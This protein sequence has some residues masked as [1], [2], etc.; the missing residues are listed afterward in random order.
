MEP[1]PRFLH[2]VVLRSIALFGQRSAIECPRESAPPRVVTFAELD[3]GGSRIA[4]LVSPH[5][6]GECIVAILLPRTSPDWLAAQ[7]GVLRAGAAFVC[8]EHSYPDER[9]SYLLTDSDAVAV[10]CEREDADRVRTLTKSAVVLDVHAQGSDQAPT[11]SWLTPNSLAYLIYTSGTTGRPKGVMIEHRSIVHLI[12]QELAHFGLGP[13]DRCVQ[14]SSPSYDSSLEE[15]WLPLAAGATVVVAGS[16]TTRLGPDLVPW[17]RVARATVL[18]PTPTLLRSMACKDPRSELPA[19]RLVYAGGEAMPRDVVDTWAPA[20]HL[21]NGYGPTE[22]TITIL[23]ARIRPGSTP[24][25]GRAIDGNRAWVLGPDLRPVARG[26]VGQLAITGI[27]VARGYWKRPELTSERFP[28]LPNIGRAYLTGDLVREN[29]DGDFDFLGRADGQVKLR[30]HRIEL[31]EIDAHLGAL[32]GIRAA[33]CRVSSTATSAWLEA[34]FVPVDPG[35]PWSEDELRVTLAETLPAHLVPTRIVAIDAL[36]TSSSGKLDRSALPAIGRRSTAATSAPAPPRASNDLEK[37]ILRA[38]SSAVEGVSIGVDDDFFEY[39]GDSLAVAMVVSQL[40]EHDAT[41][42]LAARDVYEVRTARELARLAMTRGGT[43]RSV[44]STRAVTTRTAESG[45]AA[46][47]APDLAN[48]LALEPELHRASEPDSDSDRRFSHTDN[49]NDNDNDNANANAALVTILQTLWL[50]TGMVILS[51]FAWAVVFLFVPFGIELVGLVP[52][53]LLSPFV[54]ALGAFV[55]TA[56][57]IGATLAVKRLLIGRYVARSV[58]AWSISSFRHWIVVACART[59]PWDLLRGTEFCADA[60]RLLGA[61]VGERLHV[62]RG[63]DLAGGGWDL[64]HIGDDVTF[65]QDSS[66]GLVHFEAG[67]LVIGSVTIENDCTLGVRAGIGENT[68][69]ARGTV[70]APLAFVAAGRTTS[71]DSCVDGVPAESVGR[72]NENASRNAAENDRWRARAHG[73]LRIASMSLVHGTIAC[74][75]LSLFVVL[76]VV[77]HVDATQALEWLADPFASTTSVIASAALA[78]F[79]ALALAFTLMLQALALRVL[80]KSRVGRFNRLSREAI[81]VWIRTSLVDRAGRWLSGSLY[82]RWWLRFAGMRLGKNTEVSTILDVLPEHVEIGDESFFADG[83]YLGGPVIDRGTIRVAPCEIGQ[84]VFLG[85]H[86]VVPPGTRLGDDVL[87]GVST[88]V[89]SNSM[90][91]GTSWFGHPAF[92]LPKREVVSM[93]RRLTHMPPLALW[94]HRL[95]WETLRFA[96]PIC[97]TGGAIAWLAIASRGVTRAPIA[98][99]VVAC[100]F[101]GVVWLCKW[102]LL[103]RVRPGRHAFWS[104]WCGRWDFVYMAWNRIASSVLAPLGGTLLLAIYLRLMGARIGKRVILGGAFAQLVDPD[105]LTFGDEATLD[106]P[107]FQAHS[108]EDR[109][110]KIDRITIGAR[111]TVERGTVI[112]YGAQLGAGCTVD[113]HGVVMKNEHLRPGHHYVGAPTREA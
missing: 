49:D 87:V 59:I 4:S 2:D 82:W 76:L 19:M 13:D 110:L 96:I 43:K 89:E 101:L 66:L 79:S 111:A 109:V 65:G 113:P 107:L 27:Q 74:G 3:D 39:G 5:V 10:V 83:I 41:A 23:R 7:L 93:D 63:V 84:R 71:P 73:L 108:F 75:S 40:R 78:S 8:L 35:S 95:L 64:L 55:M 90:P 81:L 103:G 105:M 72:A 54:A 25:I 104:T 86:V 14:V 12:Q 1:E 29:D 61:R 33:A 91:S 53:V 36:P 24:T 77:C 31:E 98:T 68:R 20:L 88:V 57:A 50:T 52:F 102:T 67:R 60:L 112:F 69:L 28:D 97:V 106:R 45:R 15:T 99:L 17:L 32:P 70:V 30:G 80:P 85:N 48:D 38:M 92:E 44:E 6:R 26:E 51:A 22:C 34:F 100:A 62:H 9:L 16:E 47:S 21:E 37:T 18:M 56:L 46:R 94:L 58:P 11:P 42:C